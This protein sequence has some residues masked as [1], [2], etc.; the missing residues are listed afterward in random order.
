LKSDH[1]IKKNELEKIKN[2]R[3]EDIWLSEL[4]ELLIEYEKH[5]NER[6]VQM[7]VSSSKKNKK[8]VKKK[9]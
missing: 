5:I 4:D 8:V 9:M 2:T 6:K 1:Q 3:P 7:D